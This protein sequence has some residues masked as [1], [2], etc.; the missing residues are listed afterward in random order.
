MH[1]G[2]IMVHLGAK[3]KVQQDQIN[4]FFVRLRTDALFK[5]FISFY[6]YKGPRC[7]L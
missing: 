7:S 5:T 4:D 1:N 2:V 6:V 3:D